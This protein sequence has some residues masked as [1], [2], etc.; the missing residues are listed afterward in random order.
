MSVKFKGIDVSTYQSS[1]DFS[2]V[3]AA[4]YD[5]VII[6]AGYGRYISQKDTQ[7]ETHYK[8]A[9]S[10]GLGVG[11]Y[12]YSYASTVDEAKAE[13]KV[14]LE[15]IKGKT[16]EYPIFFD[17]EESKQFAKGKS[18]CDSIVKA[19][20]NT[21]E[22]AGYYAGLYI[23]RSPLQ[24]YISSD[25]AKRYALWIA[26]Y[27]SKCNY[28]GD[29][30]MWQYSSS[31]KVNGISGNVDMDYC[32]TDYP[33]LIKGA[34]LNGFTKTATT[35]TTATNKT[36]TVKTALDSSGFAKG[37]KSNGVL[38]LKELLKIAISKKIV[39]GNVDENGTFGAG[40]QNIVNALLKK[41]G[42]KENGIAGEKF[43]KKLY[44]AIK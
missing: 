29:Y 26:E 2:K 13:A 34:G 33:T 3:K 44:S 39:S 41:W 32:Y 21:L 17:L 43:I 15:A 6:R 19:F 16:F 7:F 30:G 14:C 10:A 9:K 18:F 1:V 23:S 8:E 35:T 4:G 27:S 36:T 12:W 22:E 40:T 25:V 11:A 28:S 20:C 37:D 31:G 5:F 42:Y 38:A 24:T